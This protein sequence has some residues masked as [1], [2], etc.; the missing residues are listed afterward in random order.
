MRR[1][2]MSRVSRVLTR[3]ALVGV[4]S[5]AGGEMAVRILGDAPLPERL[6]IMTE[7]ANEL[8][9][10]EMMPNEVHYTYHHR[11]QLNSLGFRS[12]EVGEKVEGELRVLAVGDSLLYGQGVADDETIAHY[13][14]GLLEERHPE[15]EVNVIN[16]G[17][18]AYD[19]RQELGVVRE[20]GAQLQPD[21]VLVFWFWN[22]L[23]ESRIQETFDGLTEVGPVAFDVKAPM[24]GW[25][26]TKWRLQQVVRSS[27]LVMFLYDWWRATAH[28]GALSDEYVDA[29]MERFQ[30]YLKQFQRLSS[31]LGFRL[32][33]ALIPEPGGLTSTHFANGIDQRAMEL[34]EAAGVETI[35][36]HPPLA[37][38]ASELGELPII[39][40]DGH[41]LP[42]GNRVMAETVVEALSR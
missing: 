42:I 23:H 13:M 30:S 1:G 34:L 14:Q 17:H 7:R 28:D 27:A 9:G 10:W 4:G 31:E 40:Y 39:P 6:P 24:E 38:L 8:R 20:Y 35:P 16:A 33:Y 32:V 36:L 22:D 21:V 26:K 12:P 41:Y 19:T 2:V 3:L 5:F 18:R 25:V 15:R 11:V 37:A 29:G